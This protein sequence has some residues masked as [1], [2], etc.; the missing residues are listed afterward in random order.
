MLTEPFCSFY[1][2]LKSS[3][4]KWK[5]LQERAKCVVVVI[6]KRKRKCPCPPFIHDLEFGPDC[7]VRRQRGTL[8]MHHK[9]VPRHVA[10][11][12]YT[13]YFPLCIEGWRRG[14]RSTSA[15]MQ[16]MW[17]SRESLQCAIEWCT[18]LSIGFCGLHDASLNKSA[19]QRCPSPHTSEVSWRIIHTCTTTTT[20]RF[21]LRTSFRT[22]QSGGR[23]PGGNSPPNDYRAW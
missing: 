10:L 19:N 6:R 17:Q 23:R 2:V 21:Q 12:Y 7:H 1:G 15:D 18:K 9:M 13:A 16:D 11:S 8:L 14:C 22:R 20:T 4:C 3:W 5:M